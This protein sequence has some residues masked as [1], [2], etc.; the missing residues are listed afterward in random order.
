MELYRTDTE[1]ANHIIVKLSL[2]VYSLAEQLS[3]ISTNVRLYMKTKK[4]KISKFYGEEVDLDDKI[5]V[6]QKE[7]QV[8]LEST[9]P[10]DMK[11]FMFLLKI[12][13]KIEISIKLPNMSERI[14]KQ[15]YFPVLPQT[16]CLEQKTKDDFLDSVDLDD[17]RNSFQGQFQKFILEM[18]E[19]YNFSL[20][21][22]IFYL[23]SKNDTLY[24]FKFICW[25][26]GLYINVL[27]FVVLELNDL[28]EGTRDLDSRKLKSD[29][30]KFVIDISSFIFSGI[31]LILLL[32]WLIFRFPMGY[33]IK[34]YD[35]INQN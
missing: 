35:Y 2:R 27:C 9:L 28:Q 10:E 21:Y 8:K 25:I 29:N 19:N 3:G 34:E 14:Q 17:R 18:D 26:I 12:S 31:S 5:A 23:M 15:V 32:I 13:K 30:Y 7:F 16:M 20:K 24:L 33:K 1:F 11:I 4:M 22:P 6:S